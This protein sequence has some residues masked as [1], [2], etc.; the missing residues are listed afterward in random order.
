MS[1]HSLV[2]CRSSSP[3]ELIGE[4]PH[5]A[6]AKHV[7]TLGRSPAGACGPP[8]VLDLVAHRAPRR[9]H[10]DDI[11]ASTPDQLRTERRS[12]RDPTL[13]DASTRST[14]HENESLD[15]PG[16]DL[17]D[18]DRV[19]DLELV[20]IPWSVRVRSGAL[21]CFIDVVDLAISGSEGGVRQLSISRF[22]VTLEL[23]DHHRDKR[24]TPPLEPY[25]DRGSS[26]GDHLG[27]FLCGILLQ[28]YYVM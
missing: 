18:I 6:A 25:L 21:E 24:A 12:V 2:G 17:P 16:A 26:T 23:R 22:E 3:A 5:D 1:H 14:R 20:F 9:V 7:Q 8:E 19:A 13:V 4:L 28:D 15:V 27:S 11:A 10:G